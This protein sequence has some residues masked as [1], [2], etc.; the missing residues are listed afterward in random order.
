MLRRP[1]LEQGCP[2][3]AKPGLSRCPA[4]QAQVTAAH[5]R[6]RRTTTGPEAGA[7]ARMRRAVNRIGAAHCAACRATFPAD[8]VEVDH[9][10]PLADGGQDVA[11]NVQVLC[12]PCHRTKTSREAR[13]RLGGIPPQKFPA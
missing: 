9:R 2:R 8:Q 6:K 7:A 5:N 13:D 12:R 4:H 10:V 1:C 3:F 11:P